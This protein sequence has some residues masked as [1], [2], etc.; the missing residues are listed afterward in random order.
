MKQILQGE[1]VNVYGKVEEVF[2]TGR[3]DEYILYFGAYYPYHD[4]SVV[5]P[6]DLARIYS[7][8]PELYFENQHM[9][10]TGLITIFDNKP[11]IVVKRRG[12]ISLY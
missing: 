6:G 11:E 3:T 12:Q 7:R 2:Y 1:V 4:F 8:W 9:A 10:I 5:I